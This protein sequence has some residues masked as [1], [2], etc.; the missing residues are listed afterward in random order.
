MKFTETTLKGLFLITPE[1][2][3]DERGFFS[4][5]FCEREF[6]EHGLINHFVQVNNSLSRKKGTLR[7]LHYQLQP[8]SEAKLVRCIK[9]AIHDMVL[10]L[11]Q[12]SPTFGKWCGLTIDSEDRQ[13][14]YVPP[15]CAHAFLSLAD[16]TEALYFT[17]AIY[18]PDKERGIR[19]NDPKFAIQWPIVP[20]EVSSKD[21]DWPD[22]DPAF[23]LDPYYL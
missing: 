23:H 18:A 16:D 22:F 2:R 20:T 1:K 19:W 4:R 10:D 15:G 14:V 7:G 5:T 17:S 9:G 6:A 3:E 11:R 21:A 12:N 8:S 13:M